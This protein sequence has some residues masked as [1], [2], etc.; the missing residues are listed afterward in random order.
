MI[1]TYQ[2]LLDNEITKIVDLALPCEWKK[3]ILFQGFDL[4]SKSI[5]KLLY[6]CKLLD[7]PTEIFQ[8]ESDSTKPNGKSNQSGG[9][10]QS[11]FLTK[12]KVGSNQTVKYSEENRS[13]KKKPS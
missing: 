7:M 1:G 8:Y 5:G 12:S 9:I 2:G 6:F 4:V 10:Y 3:Q 11:E 13:K